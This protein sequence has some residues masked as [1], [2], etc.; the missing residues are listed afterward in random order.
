[1]RLAD[2]QSHCVPVAPPVYSAYLDDACTR[3][4]AVVAAS[5][6]CEPATPPPIVSGGYPSRACDGYVTQMIRTGARL[7]PPPNVYLGGD[8]EC[9]GVL[10]PD[11]ATYYEAALISPDEFPVVAMAME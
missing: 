7:P 2:C 1:M 9:F 10:L 11:T 4:V 6:G 8:G 5:A 3:P